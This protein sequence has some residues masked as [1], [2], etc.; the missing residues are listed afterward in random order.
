LFENQILVEGKSGNRIE[1]VY[2]IIEQHDLIKDKS[3][4]LACFWDMFVVDT[5][6]GN[7]DRHFDNWGFL[8]QGEKIEFA[9][10]YDCGS[11]LAALTED[12]EMNELLA[13]TSAFKNMEYNLTSVYYINGKRIFYHEIFGNPPNDLVEAIKRIVPK[14]DMEEIRGIVDETPM[15]SAIRKKYLKAAMRMRYEQILEPAFTKI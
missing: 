4:I 8:Q 2:E 9:P 3:N 15:L 11:A 1:S 6:I 14:I 5:L 13:N 7:P 12:E 10:I